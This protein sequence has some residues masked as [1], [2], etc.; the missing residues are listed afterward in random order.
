MTASLV[1]SAL[2]C[3]LLMKHD[4]LALGRGFQGI[5]RP[6]KAAMYWDWRLQSSLTLL[7]TCHEGTCALI[8]LRE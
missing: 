7:I 2:L 4:V 8:C 3:D 5:L 1:L 6:S